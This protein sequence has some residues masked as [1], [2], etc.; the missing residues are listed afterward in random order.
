[1]ITEWKDLQNELYRHGKKGVKAYNMEDALNK[2][3]L[4]GADAMAED[5]KALRRAQKQLAKT[6]EAVA[7]EATETE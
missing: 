1:M 5:L 4:D 6:E 2:L 7:A 3:I